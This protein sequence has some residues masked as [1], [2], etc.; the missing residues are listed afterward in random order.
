M[1][2]ELKIRTTR[3]GN[4]ATVVATGEIDLSTADELRS[5][6]TGAVDDDVEKLRLDLT[7]VE[8]IDSAGLGGLLELRST[9]RASNVRLE[10]SAGE[11][12]VRQAMEITGLSELLAR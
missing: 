6:V 1:D 12:P 9:L 2:D 10:I 4:T 5:A 7:A 3:E 8:F 11:G